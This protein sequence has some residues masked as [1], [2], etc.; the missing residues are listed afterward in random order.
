MT[1]HAGRGYPLSNLMFKLTPCRV[2]VLAL[3]GALGVWLFGVMRP[4]SWRDMAR[5]TGVQVPAGAVMS[6][7]EHPTEVGVCG[8]DEG[9]SG[10]VMAMWPCLFPT[11]SFLPF[12]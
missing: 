5:M 3:F 4:A 6:A 8:V 7:V 12:S 1:R 10:S 11:Y 9:G 2:I